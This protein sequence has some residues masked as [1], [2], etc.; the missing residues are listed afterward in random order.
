MSTP[1]GAGGGGAVV[2]GGGGGTVVVVGHGGRVVVVVLVVVDPAIVVVVVELVVVVVPSTVVV[3]VVVVGGAH[4]SV[5]DARVVAGTV[6]AAGRLVD[7]ED[8][9]DDE[10]DEVEDEVD[11]DEVDEVVD[12]EGELVTTDVGPPGSVPSGTAAADAV[13]TDIATP[14]TAMLRTRLRD[15]MIDRPPGSPQ[16]SRTWDS[17]APSGPGSSSVRPR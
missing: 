17:S 12:D 6:V 1:S 2:G 7:V 5:V 16:L 13:D 8:E 15:A 11:V 10:V 9:V 4:G 14:T 3:V